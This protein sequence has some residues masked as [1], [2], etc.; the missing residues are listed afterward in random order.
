MRPSSGEVFACTGGQFCLLARWPGKLLRRIK[1]LRGR[2]DR[3]GLYEVWK[4]DFCEGM[5]RIPA[6]LSVNLLLLPV[7][8]V[9]D[10]RQQVFR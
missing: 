2:K 6:A 4:E 10:G 1:Y 5:V 8:A 3:A 9:F 7:L